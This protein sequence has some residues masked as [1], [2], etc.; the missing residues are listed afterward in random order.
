MGV[1]T[2]VYFIVYLKTLECFIVYFQDT[3]NWISDS[4]NV[5]VMFKVREKKQHD[6]KQI[7]QAKKAEF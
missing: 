5:L 7:L 4:L 2:C 6:K 3:K 1:P